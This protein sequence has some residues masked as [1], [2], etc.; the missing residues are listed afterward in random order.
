[1]KQIMEGSRAVAETVALCRPKVVCAYPITPQTHIVEDLARIITDGRLDAGYVLADSEFT[2]AS[3]VLGASA[4]G[5]RAYTATSSQ[6]LL[7]MTEVMFNIAGMRLPVV[8][9]VANRA[10]SAPINIWNDQQDSMSLRDCGWIQMYAEDVQEACDMH[11]QAFAVAEKLNIPVMVCM[12][13]F[14]LTHATEPVDLP[15][16]D[17]VDEWLAPF[18]PKFYLTTSDPIT[19]G[20]MAGP[21]AYMEIRLLL[22]QAMQEASSAIESE[23]ERFEKAFERRQ[24]G[25]LDVYQARDADVLLVSMGSLLGTMKDAVDELREEGHKVGIVKVR[26]VRPFPR[27]HLHDA[28]SGARAV[29]VIEKDISLGLEGILCS[30]IRSAFCGAAVTPNISSFV[31]GLGGRD[32]RKEHIREIALGLLKDDTCRVEIPGIDHEV[33]WSA[34]EIENEGV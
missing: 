18:K 20:S 6:G 25:M 14:I 9:T 1:M 28:L 32:V 29:G 23:A 2:A 26:T 8:M 7:L 19:L 34:H 16:A 11:V 13:G 15:D 12:D 27:T 33:L 5:A 24:G 17:Q 4:T 30:E 10:V 31:V 21:D 3:V 22:H